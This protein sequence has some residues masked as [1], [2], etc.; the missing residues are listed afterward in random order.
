MRGWGKVAEA[1]LRYLKSN[2]DAGLYDEAPID[3][4]GFHGELNLLE[5]A[6]VAIEVL[7]AEPATKPP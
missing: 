7:D 4:V 2:S 5:I 1:I 3:G 6:R